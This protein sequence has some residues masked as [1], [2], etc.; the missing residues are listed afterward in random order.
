MVLADANYVTTN[1]ERCFVR[2]ADMGSKRESTRQ[3]SSHANHYPCLSVHE[4]VV[5]RV[6]LHVTGYDWWIS[7][8][9]VDFFI[10]YKF[11]LK[12]SSTHA[13]PFIIVRGNL[14]N[15]SWS[16]SRLSSGNTVCE[17]ILKPGSQGQNRL[18][19]VNCSQC[20]TFLILSNTTCKSK[21]LQLV[22]TILNFGKAG[23]IRECDCWS[24]QP[25]WWSTL[26]PGPRP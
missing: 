13:H 11:Q 9:W 2:N 12:T 23:F 4:F 21:S 15:P 1:W 16:F 20:S 18:T 7:T 10:F 3:V 14:T 6:W 8:R 26:D 19:G 17:E 22:K 25:A 5:Q 24:D